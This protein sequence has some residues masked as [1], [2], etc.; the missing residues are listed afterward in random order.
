MQVITG[1]Q[2]QSPILPSPLIFDS[3]NF[4]LQKAEG[5]EFPLM[6]LPRFNLPGQSGGFVSNQ[7]YGERV[8]KLT[9]VINAPDG[10]IN[11]YLA[12]RSTLINSVAIALADDGTPQPLIMQVTLQNGQVLVLGVYLSNELSSIFDINLVDD[13]NFLLQFAAPDPNL[14]AITPISTTISLASIAGTPIPTPIPMSL[15]PLSGGSAIINNPGA[16]PA[17]PSI[18]VKAPVVNPYIINFR[19][20]Q[21]LNINYTLNVGDQSLVIDCRNH[22]ITQGT[23]D[24]TGIQ[25]PDSTFF[26]I[27]PGAN[28]IGYSAASGSGTITVLI[29]PVYIG[30]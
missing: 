4:I 2:I 8:V 26:N 15:L 16:V 21:F 24:V 23:N 9:G 19:T 1:L 27:L 17:P 30:V 28:T 14:Y 12:N 3:R 22:R 18:T 20:G 10:K 7:L 6:R 25:S 13:G 5:F 29:F 11:T